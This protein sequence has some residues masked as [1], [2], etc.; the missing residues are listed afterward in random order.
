MHMHACTAILSI[1]KLLPPKYFV[2][3]LGEFRII[4]KTTVVV[5]EKK[6]EKES[7]KK[8]K[9]VSRFSPKKAVF[10][11]LPFLT[12]ESLLSSHHM[13]F[14]IVHETVTPTVCRCEGGRAGSQLPNLSSREQLIRW[15]YSVYKCVIILLATS[16]SDS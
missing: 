15:P 4:Y 6:K 1:Y 16:I 10:P 11:C 8:K 2:F 3:H 7:L 9:K 14:W 5:Q 13:R 12:S